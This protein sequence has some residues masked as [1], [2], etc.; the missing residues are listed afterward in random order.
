MKRSRA[1]GDRGILI[2]QMVKDDL[3]WSSAARSMRKWAPSPFGTAASNRMMK[4]VRSRRA[5]GRDDARNDR[6][7]KAG[8]KLEGY[9][10]KPACTRGVVKAMVAVKLM[11]TA[12]AHRLDRRQPFLTTPKPASRS[13]P[14]RA[15]QRS[16]EEER[17]GALG[18]GRPL[19]ATAASG[20]R[21][22]ETRWFLT[23]PHRRGDQGWRL[24][25]SFSKPTARRA[26]ANGFSFTGRSRGIFGSDSSESATRRSA[27]EFRQHLPHVVFVLCDQ[28]AFEP[29]VA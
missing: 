22:A 24:E 8:V 26:C 5:T 18:R 27:A 14:D 29:A 15:E 20:R 9:R 16:R 28:F 23:P 3:E 6:P 13:R 21:H 10:G 4:D 11:Q 19:A 1:S 2:A 12:R 25:R 17:G 7:P